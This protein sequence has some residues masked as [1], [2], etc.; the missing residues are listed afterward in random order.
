MTSPIP[1]G[2]SATG[3][4]SAVSAKSIVLT[5][6]A[7]N[8]GRVLR[9]ALAGRIGA[10]RIL[11]IVDPGELAEHESWTSVDITDLAALTAAVEGADAIVHFAG[12][13]N[14]RAAED[15]LRVNVLGTHNVY[16]A[17]VR[18][19]IDRVVQASSNHV[20][21]FY[22]R[23]ARVGVEDQMRPD[24]LYGLSKCWGEL[25]AGVYFEKAGIRTLAIRIGNAGVR[26]LDAR[27]L[28]VWIS[29][30]DLAQLVLIGLEHPDIDCTTVYGASATDAAWW[31]NSV[32]TAL[33]YRPQD[34]T[35]DF[36]APE[37]FQTKPSDLPQ[38]TD[39]FQG[40]WFSAQGHD[41]VER[42]RRVWRNRS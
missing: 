6:G 33:G 26:P 35:V 27:G 32:A 31:D 12:Y 20:T 40:G 10:V 18:A 17:A 29:P 7:G 5:G 42:R 34:R 9:R 38:V 28:A 23:D 24:G 3:A 8:V 11:D 30:R 14:E 16:E 15:M 37:A 25:E 4:E 1:S 39:H 13:P 21:G 19:G 36:A 2:G 41:G 22:P